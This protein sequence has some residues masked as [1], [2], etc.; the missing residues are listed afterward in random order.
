M[1]DKLFT[2]AVLLHPTQEEEGKGERTIILLSP[3]NV[4]AIDPEEAKA[5]IL[6]DLPNN[7][8]DKLNR[9]EVLVRPF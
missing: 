7:V 9:V 2:V 4:L 6:M 3:E 8:K 5:Q 1:K